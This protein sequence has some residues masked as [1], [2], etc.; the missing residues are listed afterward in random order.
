M[1]HFSIAGTRLHFCHPG[2][3]ERTAAPVP[4]RCGPAFPARRSRDEWRSKFAAQRRNSGGCPLRRWVRRAHT[5]RGMRAAPSVLRSRPEDRAPAYRRKSNSS[6]RSCCRAS[7]DKMGSRDSDSSSR[8]YAPS[9]C[10]LF[11][12]CLRSA[13]AGRYNRIP[14]VY[15]KN[16]LRLHHG[17]FSAISASE[18]LD[19]APL[20]LRFPSLN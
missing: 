12:P 3:A 20:N 5:Y 11:C 19:L 8:T 7:S 4:D 14:R 15:L 6:R 16:S 13:S 1:G 18:N 2:F 9:R 10:R 17:V